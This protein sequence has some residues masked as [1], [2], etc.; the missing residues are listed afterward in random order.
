MK[1]GD[2]RVQDSE[3]LGRGVLPVAGHDEMGVLAGLGR[4]L[5]RSLSW[6]LGLA[7]AAGVVAY[8]LTFLAEVRY[9]ST[10]QVMIDTREM[11]DNEFAPISGLPVS[12]TALESELEVLRSLDIID[13]VVQRLQL[14]IDPEFAP[15]DDGPGLLG[16]ARTALR[17][18]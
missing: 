5:R 15:D 16:S 4:A 3:L 14:G 13:H 17:E 9:T 8:V 7:F 1:Q 2:V 6:I 10:A 18:A 11:P 12:L